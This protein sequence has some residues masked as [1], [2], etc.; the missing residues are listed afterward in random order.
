MAF[1]HCLYMI[2][3]TEKNNNDNFKR[4]KT[5][6]PEKEKYSHPGY[7]GFVKNVMNNLSSY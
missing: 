6:T 5:K 2:D 4:P 1:K 3:C 7:R